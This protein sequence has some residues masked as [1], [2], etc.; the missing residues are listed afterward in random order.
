MDS[1]DKYGQIKFQVL[2]RCPPPENSG[3]GNKTLQALKQNG[4]TLSEKKLW[5]SA[6]GHF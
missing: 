4:T 5:F 6:C 3:E 2:W 1:R